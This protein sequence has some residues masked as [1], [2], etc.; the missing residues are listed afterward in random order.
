MSPSRL[1]NEKFKSK[2]SWRCRWLEQFDLHLFDDEQILEVSVWRRN[3]Q[4]GRCTIDL[5]S[6]PRES[7]H[8]MWQ[9]L[10]ES[11][12]EVYLMLTISGTTA[13]ETITD[14][15]SYREDP[16]DRASLERRY[17]LR[18]SFDNL[19]DVGHLTV[20]I[21]GATGLFGADLG[22]KSDPFCVIELINSRLQTQTEYK[23][24]SPNWNK[25]FTFNV[26]DMTSVL[27]ITVYDED[28]DHKVEFLGRVVIPL[29]RIRNGEKR[30]Y[31]LKDKT[32]CVRAKGASPQILLE[33]TVVWNRLRA[34]IRA[35]EPKEEKLVQQEAKFKR[36]VFLRNVTRLKAIIMYVLCM[37]RYV[38]SCF[39]WESPV[40]SVFALIF[41]VV[42]CLWMDIS[43]IPAIGLLFLLK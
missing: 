25:I 33:M 20:K 32:T 5:R 23:T 2:T 7:T 9:A 40:R 37:C 12:G 28:R 21:F 38:Q 36:Q 29:L 27:D 10:D 6:L 34:A 26:K 13:S 43:A 18:S 30:W 1:G 4:L 15:T 31:A 39:E 16:R 8:N 11:A 22:G 24:L 42:G 14:L 19:R 35:L 41:W 3:T 17:N